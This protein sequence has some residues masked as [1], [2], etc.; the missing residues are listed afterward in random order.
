MEENK[1]AESTP[2]VF[3]MQRILIA[4]SAGLAAMIIFGLWWLFFVAPANPAGGLGW[5]LFAFATGLTM[6]VLP[7]TLPLAFVIVPLSMGKG[8]VR[9]VSIAL[10]F[11]A[12][13]ALMLS[14]YGILAAL[15][16]GAAIGQL[17]AP[18]EVVKNWVYFIAGIFA[19]LF[20]L[21]EIGLIKVRMPSYT[22]AAPAFIQKRGDYIKA[23]LL[24]MFLGN[25]GVGCPHPATPLLLIEIATSGNVVYGWTLF[26]T[27]AIGRILPLIL[28]AVL[29]ISGVNGLNWLV[30]KKDK[31]ERATGWAMVFVAG[32]ILTLGL[33][34][35]AW[36]VSSGIHTMLEKVTQE[37]AFLGALNT[38]LA[39]EDVAHSHGT[40]ELVGQTGLFGLPLD[41]GNYVLVFLWIFPIW[42]WWH[43]EKKRIEAIPADKQVPEKETA[44]TLWRYQE[45][46]FTVLSLLLAVVFIW[47]LPQWFLATAGAPHGHAAGTPAEHGHDTAMPAD[48]DHAANTPPEHAHDP[49]MTPG[50]PVSS[51]PMPFYLQMI[52][53]DG[54]PALI[55]VIFPV[56]AYPV[57][58]IGEKAKMIGSEAMKMG[59]DVVGAMSSQSMTPV[60]PPTP[61][62]ME[63][64]ATMD[65]NA[66]AGHTSQYHEEIQVTSGLAVS[67]SVTPSQPVA[68][69]PVMM[70]FSVETRPD[71]APYDNLTLAHEKYLHI[72]GLR[73]DLGEFLHLHPDKMTPGKWTLLYTFKEAGRYKLYADVVDTEGVAH[74]FGQQMIGVAAGEGEFSDVTELPVEYLKNVVIGGYQV[75]MEYDTPLVAG[76][77]SE[78]RFTVTDVYDKGVELDTYLGVSMHL[79][80]IS[81][82]LTQY[83]HTHPSEQSSGSAPPSNVPGAPGFDESKPHSHSFNFNIGAD[84]A[85]AH[86]ESPDAGIISEPVSF[87]LPFAKPG[88]YRVFAQ[89]RPKGADL[90][91]GE[92]VVAAFF[93]KVAADTGQTIAKLPPIVHAHQGMS[94]N[95]FKVL[96]VLI[97]VILMGLLSGF[98]YK[99]IQVQ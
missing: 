86:V 29:A 17:G 73:D 18:L 15:I 38:K 56:S 30:T 39:S 93:V 20:A 70:T 81:S 58:Q 1:P 69:K 96:L 75:A 40:A 80:G 84:I 25:V 3:G 53:K 47:A 34:S 33:F 6:I 13:V 66:H 61:H 51:S 97:S 26:L 55:P 9:G 21:G 5:Y 35:H 32:F 37:H 16:G 72:V 52:D 78:M 98:V 45:R 74:T 31:I 22:G 46:M 90:K 76:K 89:F 14:I 23:F 62:V 41:L 65:M 27:H 79:G 8:L 12:G 42:W 77:T 7:C 19:L 11:G 92:A 24:G 99:K 63:D 68:G 28:L 2:G 54:K 60:M 71:N 48:H 87:A 88:V 10:S 85:E 50:V 67:M 64:G 59:S 95:A 49:A 44:H 91:A 36:W 4:A 43:R 57:G 83:V 82:D 94:D